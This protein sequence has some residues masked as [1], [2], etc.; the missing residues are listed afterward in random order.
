MFELPLIQASTHVRT[1]GAQWLSESRRHGRSRVC[2]LQLAHDYRRGLARFRLDRRRLL[3][4]RLHFFC[5]PRDHARPF[6]HEY[7]RR[8][9]ASRRAG[10]HRGAARR[11]PSLGVLLLRLL[12]ERRVAA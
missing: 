9:P 3:V 10:V 8:H 4:H 11:R 2:R 7:L 12:T 5:E 1:G 6:A